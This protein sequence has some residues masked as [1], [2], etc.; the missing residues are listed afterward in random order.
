[1]KTLDRK[2]IVIYILTLVFLGIAIQWKKSEVLADRAKEEI[3]I[4][5]EIALHG[6]PVDIEVVKADEIYDSTRVTVIHDYGAKDRVSFW[7]SRKQIQKVKPGQIVFGLE[8]EEPIGKVLSVSSTPSIENGLYKGVISLNKPLTTSGQTIQAV[9]IVTEVLKNAISVPM[10]ALDNTIGDQGESYVWVEK[11]GK[12]YPTKIKIGTLG[13]D[14]IEVQSGLKIGDR[15]VSNGQKI[16]EDG[17]KLRIREVA[18]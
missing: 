7:L 14:R 17:A 15:V 11:D 2:R 13:H 3:T 8:D 16:L 12:A 10:E 6:I 1:M 9:D 5:R 4:P 18:E